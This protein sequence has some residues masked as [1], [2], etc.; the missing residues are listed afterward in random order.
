MYFQCRKKRFEQNSRILKSQQYILGFVP[1]SILF[2]N[3]VCYGIHIISAYDP[4][5]ANGTQSQKDTCYS[6]LTKISKVTNRQ[7]LIGGDMNA[8]ANF[9]KSF[10]SG[11]ENNISDAN[12]NG[13][14]LAN[15][16]VLN[17]LSL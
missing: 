14:R 3:C 11:K 9:G 15:Y 10:M 2:I 7:L 4:T 16:I 13:E 17:G 6:D 8:T 5:E 12:D 1:Q